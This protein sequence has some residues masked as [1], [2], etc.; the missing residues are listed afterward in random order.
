MDIH[1]LFILKETGECIYSRIFTQK[2]EK[3]EVNIISPFFSAFFTFSKEILSEH[4]DMLEMG[5]YRFFFKKEKKYIFSLLADTTM[6]NL[7]LKSSL[8]KIT[9]IFLY[10][11]E[12]QRWSVD[13]LIDDTAF[14]TVIDEII[15]GGSNIA[16]ELVLYKKIEDYFKAKMKKNGIIGAALL[17]SRGEIFYTSLPKEILVSSLK[18]FEIKFISGI[19]ALPELF[20]SLENGR[21][22]FSKQMTQTKGNINFL[23]VLL[24]ESSVPLGM[25]ELSLNRITKELETNF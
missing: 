7:Y 13:E 9:E 2:F 14:D 22:V 5:N 25:A 12:N 10:G 8:D 16:K 3:L 15:Y 21:K 6:S 23:I 4:L 19:T 24:F 1:A 17:S 11:M 20:Y 18:E